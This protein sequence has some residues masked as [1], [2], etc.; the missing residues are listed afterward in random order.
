M[1]CK[2]ALEIC[3][4]RTWTKKIDDT[5]SFIGLFY[6]LGNVRVESQ[7]LVKV[8]VQMLMFI[9]PVDQNAIEIKRWV[10]RQLCLVEKITSIGG[11]V[12]SGIKDM[13]H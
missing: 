11:L 3:E 2:L 5:Y 1:T 7:L 4:E 12:G 10:Y 9:N 13:R 8:K 6:S